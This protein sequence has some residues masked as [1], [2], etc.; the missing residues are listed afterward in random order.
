MSCKSRVPLVV[1]C[2]CTSV[3]G[4]LYHQHVALPPA[5]GVLPSLSTP[6]SCQHWVGLRPRLTSP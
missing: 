4:L 6:T 1:M 5:D 2:D 3:G